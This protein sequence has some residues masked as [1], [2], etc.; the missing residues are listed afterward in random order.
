MKVHNIKKSSFKQEDFFTKKNFVIHPDTQERQ[1]E[2]DFVNTATN[3]KQFL[4]KDVS[5]N[6]YTIADLMLKKLPK[7]AEHQ[8]VYTNYYL[9]NNRGDL[10]QDV[11][12]KLGD[13]FMDRIENELMRTKTPISLLRD[14]HYLSI[15]G[16]DRKNRVLK[17]KDSLNDGSHINDN[18]DE[19]IDVL[20]GYEKFQLIFP[21]YM[22]EENMK[23]LRDKFE[24]KEDLYDEE[25]KE[26]NVDEQILKNKK[27]MLANPENMLHA[28]G[29]E[30]NVKKRE[31]DFE[32]HFVEEQIYLPRNLDMPNALKNKNKKSTTTKNTTKSKSTATKGDAKTKSATTS[33]KSEKKPDVKKEVKKD[34]KTKQNSKYYMSRLFGSKKDKKDDK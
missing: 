31:Y 16:V 29:Y 24:L 25:T 30:F 9:S 27:N 8:L 33:K 23:Y 12:E 4:T 6:P 14:G 34:D 2:Q 5:G 28:E 20:L 19:S 18:R 32:Q 10:P 22:D 13:Y 11:K 7:T 21:E 17:T 1:K 26:L 3:I 15:T